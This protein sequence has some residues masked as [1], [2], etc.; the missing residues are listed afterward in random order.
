MNKEFEKLMSERPRS[1]ADKLLWER[2]VNKMFK[3]REASLTANI[4]SLQN[5]IEIYKEELFQKQSSGKPSHLENLKIITDKYISVREELTL[6]KERNKIIL[7]VFS[8]TIDEFV[9]NWPRI[10]SAEKGL[11]TKKT[12]PRVYFNELLKTFIN[13]NFPNLKQ[14]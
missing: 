7:E 2:Q 6:E 12:K 9:Q 5:E 11:F 8:K 14:W 1:L 4:L 13:T 3:E 10:V